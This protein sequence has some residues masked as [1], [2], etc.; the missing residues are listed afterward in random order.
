M[1]ISIKAS[2]LLL[3][4][5]F[6]VSCKNEKQT[7]IAVINWSKAQNYYLENMRTSIAYLDSLKTEG[8]DGDKSKQFFTLAREAFKKA[9]PYASY[10]NPEVGHRVNGPALPVYKEDSGKILNPVG[11]QKIEESIYNQD[12]N[13]TDFDQEVYVTNGMLSVLQKG[14]EKRKLTPQRFFIATHQQL[15]RIVSLAISGFDTPVSHL[16][17]NETKISLE[18]LKTV[19]Q[20]SIQSII[21]NKN[22]YLDEAFLN[23]IS[24]AILF[25]D[26]N[27]QFDTFDRF[28]FTRDYLNPITRNWVDIRKT[29]QLWEAVTTEAFNFDAP[30]FFENNS[31][32]L[33]FFTPATNR[34]PSGK[35][36]ALGEKLFSDPKL[37]AS[38]NMACITCHIPSKGYA[39]GMKVN[40]DT[41][42]KPL[43]RNTPTLLNTAFQQS[44]FLD[45]RASSLIDQISLV[46]TNNKEFNTNVHEFSDAILKDST[47]VLLFKDAYGKIS[48]NNKDVIKA[49]SSYI[50]TLNGFNSKFDKNIRGEENTFTDE[51]K[52]GY[53]LF[54]GKALCATC[55]FIPL[56]NGTVP[57]F[58]SET[59][60]E[61]IGVPQTAKNKQLDTDLGFY[62]K[63]KEALHKGMFKTPSIRNIEKT[64]PYMHNGV[65]ETLE[66]VVDFY[67]QGG[68]N[69]FGF[70]IA[71]QTLPF[72]ELNLTKTEQTSIIAFMKTLTDSDTQ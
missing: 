54:M 8:F 44:F 35:Q 52:H 62:W 43:Q 9:E 1:N 7:T 21:Q 14:I 20:H 40:L 25:I 6:V 30:T 67:N 37:S 5:V 24:K 39:D 13:K 19:Y 46:F 11:F 2:T 34:N 68:G 4:L 23:N 33:N 42:G 32:N 59:E 66:E 17:I 31:F 18:G 53:N 49:I 71:H 28:T 61:V 69:G 50:S 70:N 58:F 10:L 60:K 72:D 36:I 29:S 27:N 41:H 65:Y 15:F 47:Y 63:Y 45:G 51:E 22:V 57:P 38:G 48:K 3:F 12:T 26:K 16:G 56:T 64:A 55:H